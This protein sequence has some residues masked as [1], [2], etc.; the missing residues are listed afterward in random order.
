MERTISHQETRVGLA[1]HESEHNRGCQRR[2][3]HVRGYKRPVL[4]LTQAPPLDSPSLC[5][6]KR[7]GHGYSGYSR[8]G[9]GRLNETIGK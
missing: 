2:D 3:S 9:R 1:R 6:T 4:L 7:G 5:E 8:G